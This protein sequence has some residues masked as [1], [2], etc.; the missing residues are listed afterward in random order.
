M[1]FS[2]RIVESLRGC[3]VY[4]CATAGPPVAGSDEPEE[5]FAA[6]SDLVRGTD[7]RLCRQRVFVPEGQLPAYQAAHAKVHGINCDNVPTTWL[8]AGAGRGIGG[9][10]GYGVSE[11][12]DWKPLLANGR[13]AG[14][15]FQQ[16]GTRWAVTAD[17]AGGATGDP[18]AQTAMAFA[19]A[20]SVLEQAGLG[21]P[22]LARTWFFLRDILGWYGP[23]NHVRNSLFIERGLLQR[24]Q[25]PSD[26]QVP[27]STGIGVAP[28]DGRH[29]ALEIVAL[30]G[31]TGWVKRFAAMG[32]QRC[33]YEYGSA[34]AR[35][36]ET[37]TPAGRTIFVSGTAA[38]DQE[39]HTCHL[40]DPAGQIRMTIHNIL[41]VLRDAGCGGQHVVEAMA[42][43][44]TPEVAEV[45]NKN[46]Q[47][48][49]HWPW[50]TVIGDVC[51]SDLLFEA[52]VT[53]CIAAT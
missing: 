38:I 5:M 31:D 7:S 9:V 15:T 25:K 6:V 1:E 42:Y 48:E 10:Q 23:F 44:K 32:R 33:A 18:S 22:K 17:L 24:G 29:V 3:E 8:S 40:E 37:R 39:G 51:R 4:A 49:I 52:E 2:H 43:C 36:A 50:M 41:A 12:T 47:S 30:G 21:L 45:F 35:A 19:S 26:V 53:A 14:W 27:A 46:W 28:A 34:F 20:E 13:T 11:V 16:E